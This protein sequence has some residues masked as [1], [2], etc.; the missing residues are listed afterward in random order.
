[1]RGWLGTVARI[2]ILCCILAVLF[3]LRVY[4]RKGVVWV[5][6]WILNHKEILAWLRTT[7]GTRTLLGV[8]AVLFWFLSKV[9]FV[10]LVILF[11]LMWLKPEWVFRKKT[12]KTT[13]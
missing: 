7:N 10:I 9:I 6:S 11:V 2:S 4:I 13:D 3:L 1:M 8:G 12:A 5:R